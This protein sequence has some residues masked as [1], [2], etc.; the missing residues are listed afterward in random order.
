MKTLTIILLIIFPFMLIAQSPKPLRM[1]LEVKSGS[2]N[3]NIIPFEKK[4]LLL[5]YQSVNRQTVSK[6]MTFAKYDT[7]FNKVWNDEIL[8]PKN[9]DL[10]K[11]DFDK[12]KDKIYFLFLKS[13]KNSVSSYN[14]NNSGNFI[15]LTVDFSNGESKTTNGIIADKLN[16]NE[17]K[18][19]G[20]NAFIGGNSKPANSLMYLS[21]FFSITFIPMLTGAGFYKFSPEI[22][23]I[24][25]NNNIIRKIKPAF[26]SN[27]YLL[28]EQTSVSSETPELTA[29]IKNVLNRKKSYLYFNK[30]NMDGDL[31]KS[32]NIDIPSDSTIVTAKLN[33]LNNENLLTGTFNCKKRHRFTY[34]PLYNAMTELMLPSDGLF[35]SKFTSNKPDYIKFYSFKNFENYN[36]PSIEKEKL[37]LLGKKK[38]F[39]YDLRYIIHDIIKNNNEYLLIAEA[40]YPEYHLEYFWATDIHGRAYQESREV[41]DGF[42]YSHAIIAAFDVNGKKLW[43]NSFE[44]WN[45]LTYNLKER[46]NVIF[47]NDNIVLSYSNEGKIASKIIHKNQVIQPKEETRIDFSQTKNDQKSFLTSDM[48]Y[49]Y[50]NYFINFGYESIDPQSK[51]R[52]SKTIFYINKIAFQ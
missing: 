8:I 39:S 6:I 50:K 51:S 13:R 12:T 26:K 45:I 48:D 40:Y 43:D 18:V 33:N 46:I 22:I 42:R 16:I 30:Y 44:I 7:L 24:N 14:S 31:I 47:D 25:L 9:L 2:D 5:Y 10:V 52:N 35:F 3:F 21:A 38:V 28:N 20:D 23:C 37:K 17:F 27:S 49:W 4:G 19:I 32:E 29:I 34:N 41:F 1:E 15:V 36:N 11:Y